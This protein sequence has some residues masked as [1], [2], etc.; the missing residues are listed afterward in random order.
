MP[1]GFM[2]TQRQ[3][4]TELA[5]R[6]SIGQRRYTGRNRSFDRP[7]RNPQFAGLVDKV[8]IDAIAR[9]SNDSLG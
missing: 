2:T 6:C 9:T 4:P 7:N 3:L 5:V 8:G 1:D